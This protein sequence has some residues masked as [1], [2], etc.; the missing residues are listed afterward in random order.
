MR[1]AGH[2]LDR[3]LKEVVA[4]VQEG[5]TTLE[6]DKLAHSRIKEAK[7]KPAFLRLY[8]FPNTL[9]ISVNEEVVHGIPGKRKLV[10]G[11]VISIDCGVGWKG[12]FADGAYTAAVGEVSPETR[13]LMDVTKESLDRA[14]EQCKPGNRLGDIGWA[15]QSHVEANGLCI[16][17]EYGGH[18]IGRKVHEDPRVENYGQAGKGLRL[19]P[20]MVI[21][22]EPMVAIGTGKTKV[23]SDDWTVVTRDGSL[24]AHYEHTVAITEDG[25]EILTRST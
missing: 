12:F 20:G 9:C 23:L 7:A 13:R 19:K 17:E 8:G 11:D 1:H 24:A 21:A 14:I 10:P 6:L 2:L 22:I 15:V 3:V 16:I 4:N 25:C 5:V 18:G